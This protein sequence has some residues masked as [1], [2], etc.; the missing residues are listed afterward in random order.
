MPVT[1]PF[2][3]D[4]TQHGQIAAQ[5]TQA[6]QAAL[7]ADPVP[8]L[9]QRAEWLARDNVLSYRGGPFGALVVQM[10]TRRVCGAAANHATLWHDATAHA[11]V[12]ALRAATE[13]GHDL[14][15]CALITSCECCP[16]CLA[17]TFR[18][19]IRRI[20]Y[21]ATR[22]DAAQAGFADA[23]QYALIAQ[24]ISAQATLLTTQDPRHAHA[25]SMLE[26]SAACV[27]VPG[28]GGLRPFGR[29]DGAPPNDPTLTPCIQAMRAACAA[30]GNP[31]LPSGSLL[32]SRREP[33]PLSLLAAD[34]ANLGR[35]NDLD[36]PAKHPG[37]ILYLDSR[38]EIAPE[39]ALDARQ[40]W[41]ALRDPHA[42]GMQC[43]HAPLPTEPEAFPAWIA[44]LEKLQRY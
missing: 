35:G 17:S 44:N 33:H 5:L 20:H 43:L 6:W 18:A 22:Q 31:R 14:R 36:D 12:L 9:L 34:W 25:A 4:T 3:A 40:I 11:E 8:W 41:A 7:P 15:G 27:L 10:Q 21:R 26:T 13:G 29:A 37:A 2:F 1:P 19:G 42:F 28:A 23:A 16:M 32:I 38:P 39:E 24:P 30:W